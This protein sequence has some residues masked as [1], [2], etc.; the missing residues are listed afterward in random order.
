MQLGYKRQRGPVQDHNNPF[1]RGR[2]ADIVDSDRERW[3]SVIS[4]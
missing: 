4:F 2:E 3:F 1:H